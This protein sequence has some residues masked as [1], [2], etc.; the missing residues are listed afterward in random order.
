ME[1]KHVHRA[2]F[3]A[4]VER[5][6]DGALPARGAEPLHDLLDERGVTCVEQSIQCFAIPGQAHLEPSSETTRD[7]LQ[8]RQSKRVDLAALGS[9]D[10]G[11]TRMSPLRQVVLGEVLALPQSPELSAEPNHLHSSSMNAGN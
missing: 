11:P 10:L 8:G 7:P 4:D 5:H 6:L 1:G 3:A 2:A 9:P